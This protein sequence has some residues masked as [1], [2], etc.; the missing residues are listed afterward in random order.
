M[1]YPISPYSVPKQ[2]VKSRIPLFEHPG[3]DTPT[4]LGIALVFPASE[5]AATIE[6]IVGSVGHTGE[7]IQ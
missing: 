3:D 4:V 1:L 5:N 2:G 6:Y 7:P